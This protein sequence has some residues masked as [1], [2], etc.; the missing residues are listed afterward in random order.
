MIARDKGFYFG[1]VV[2]FL[3]FDFLLY[4]QNVLYQKTIFVMKH[5]GVRAPDALLDQL[6]MLEKC[7]NAEYKSTRGLLYK[8]GEK[9]PLLELTCSSFLRSINFF[10]SKTIKTKKEKFFHNLIWY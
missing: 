10:V 7:P 4:S 3:H 8:M 5:P 9:I 2:Y 6:Q 1:V